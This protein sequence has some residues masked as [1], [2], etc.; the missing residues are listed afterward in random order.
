MPAGKTFAFIGV[1]AGGKLP[2]KN[3]PG[4]FPQRALFAPRRDARAHTSR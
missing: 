2:M 1:F 3:F 4:F